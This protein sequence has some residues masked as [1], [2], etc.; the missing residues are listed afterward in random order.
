[1]AL[2]DG[3]LV[4]VGLGTQGDVPPNHLQPAL[5]DGVHLR[6]APSRELGFPW[7]GFYL[8]RREHRRGE[9]QCLS[10]Q[11]RDH[12]VGVLSSS[13]YMTPIGSIESDRPLVLT[14]DF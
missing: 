4:M 5:L 14:D 8:Y 9:P 7:Y 10:G 3:S 1:M 6:W 12:H 11:V 13:Q 2:Q